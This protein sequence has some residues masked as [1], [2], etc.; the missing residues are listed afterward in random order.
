MAQVAEILTVEKHLGQSDGVPQLDAN[1][2]VRP[3]HLPVAPP[4]QALGTYLEQGGAVT[5]LSNLSFRVQAGRAVINGA[6]V[7]WVQT[8]VALDAADPSNPRQDSIIIQDN[9]DG[10]GTPTKVTGTPAA[11]PATPDLDPLSQLFLSYALVPAGATA[12]T[13]GTTTIY[14]ED[15]DWTSSVSGGT[16]V[17][18]ST[19]NPLAGTKSVEATNA[20]ANAFVRFTNGAP[21][22]LADARQLHCLI[23]PKAAFPNAKG[24]RFTWYLA[25]VKKGQSVTV[26]QSHG[27]SKSSTATQLVAIPVSAFQLPAGTTVDRLEIMVTGG[28]GNVGFWLDDVILE[29]TSQAIT[30]IT[31][32]PASTSQS[33]TV[34]I[35]TADPDPIAALHGRPLALTFEFGDGV[36]AAVVGQKAHVILPAGLSVAFVDWAATLHNV[37]GSATF[38]VRV[39]TSVTAAYASVGGTQPSVAT[40][41]GATGS[42]SSWT[43]TGASALQMVEVE[44]TALTTASQATLI[45]GVRPT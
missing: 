33:G 27:F 28:G 18:G 39:A 13:I 35:A 37:T 43:T 16:V 2:I 34:K 29:A 20:A 6:R 31:V 23:K 40:A 41:K 25:G 26:E 45:I 12:L 30:V 14:D 21:V 11:S 1:G 8:D 24:L 15:D 9:G 3:A 19:S 4:P 44:L 7:T 5:F 32:G 22:S 38:A 17:A 42:A 36:T 10:T